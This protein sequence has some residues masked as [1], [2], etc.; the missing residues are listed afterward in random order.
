MTRLGFRKHH[1]SIYIILK[2]FFDLDDHALDEFL[3]LFMQMGKL[4]LDLQDIYKVELE[5]MYEFV[6]IIQLVV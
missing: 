5:S 6:K 3:S 2:P 4:P 1:P